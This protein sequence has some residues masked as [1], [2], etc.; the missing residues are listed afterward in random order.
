MVWGMRLVCQ[1][2]AHCL[3]LSLLRPASTRHSD[4][5]PPSWLGLVLGLRTSRTS[6]NPHQQR[7]LPVSVPLG[8]CSSPRPCVRQKLMGAR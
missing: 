2:G 6:S 1:D 8:S 5:G 4:C 3:S 7:R